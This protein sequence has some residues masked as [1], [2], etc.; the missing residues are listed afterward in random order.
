MQA[1]IFDMDSLLIDS[2]PLWRQ[3]ERQVFGTVGITLTEEMCEQTMGLRTDE[4]VAHWY[5]QF[6]WSACP[7]PYVPHNSCQN[8]RFP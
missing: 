6:R 2:E 8:Q 3:A 5:Q 7:S 1:A 4:V